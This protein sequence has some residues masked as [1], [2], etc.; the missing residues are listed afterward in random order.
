[1]INRHP[2]LQGEDVR[3]FTKRLNWGPPFARGEK[4]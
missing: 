4:K 2:P 1:M 3:P